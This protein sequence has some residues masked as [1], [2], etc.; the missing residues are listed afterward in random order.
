MSY[1]TILWDLYKV[2]RLFLNMVGGKGATLTSFAKASDVSL[3]TRETKHARVC[4]P[5]TSC[6]IKLLA[7]P[8]HIKIK[9]PCG[10]LF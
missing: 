9:A 3:D 1:S 4:A 7:P 2:Q 10:A 5:C 8:T 6:K